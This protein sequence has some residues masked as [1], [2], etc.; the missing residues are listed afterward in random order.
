MRQTFA[1]IMCLA[2]L[3]AGPAVAREVSTGGPAPA[4]AG[5]SWL[6][7]L[8]TDASDE[9]IDLAVSMVRKAVATAQSGIEALRKLRPA[10]AHDPGNL[11]DV[12]G[13]SP[14]TSPRSPR[15]TITGATGRR[16]P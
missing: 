15:R 4:V 12:S 13:V 14:P 11:I 6:P 16:V 2:A 3:A 7:T 8:L 5:E 1:T 10:Y 9:G